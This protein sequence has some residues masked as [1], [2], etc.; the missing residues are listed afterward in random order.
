MLTD[1]RGLAFC[2]VGATIDVKKRLAQHFYDSGTPSANRK[3]CWIRELAHLGLKPTAVILDT[4]LEEEARQV[5]QDLIAVIRATRG[6][7]LLNSIH[8][9][10]GRPS[11][12]FYKTPRGFIAT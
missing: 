1:P 12:G 11:R 6:H 5:E 10:R 3:F 8:V 9:G 7:Y 2:Y 4:V